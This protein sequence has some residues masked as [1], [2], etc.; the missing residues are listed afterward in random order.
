MPSQSSSMAAGFASWRRIS[1]TSRVRSHIGVTLT[2]APANSTTTQASP[3][4]AR[5]NAASRAPRQRSVPDTP[6]PDHVRD[7]A[8]GVAGIAALTSPDAMRGSHAVRTASV[9]CSTIACAAES[10]AM[11]GPGAA[12]RPSSVCRMA[13]PWAP[14]PSPPYCSGMPQPSQPREAACDHR[15]RSS[16]F[17]PSMNACSPVLP[18]CSASTPATPSRKA[19]SVAWST[20]S[21]VSIAIVAMRTSVAC[22]CPFPR[23]VRSPAAASHTVEYPS[24]DP[25]HQARACIARWRA[26]D[27]SIPRSTPPT[28]IASEA[29][30]SPAWVH[31][32]SRGR[33]LRCARNDGAGRGIQTQLGGPCRSPRCAVYCTDRPAGPDRRRRDREGGNQCK[34]SPARSPW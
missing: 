5:T 20:A 25:E 17:L 6:A 2:S 30:Q 11:Y 19:S 28:V 31:W 29:K 13:R 24:P 14:R 21:A 27:P 1:I 18:L 33:L 8:P 9:P 23:T 4:G 26:P 34:T 3:A 16:A 32:I 12:C 7:A 22:G 10:V 15:S